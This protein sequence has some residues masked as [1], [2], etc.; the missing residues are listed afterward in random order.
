MTSS[1]HHKDGQ[2]DSIFANLI[3]SEWGYG[4]MFFLAPSNRVMCLLEGDGIAD[5]SIIGSWSTSGVAK[6]K[7]DSVTGVEVTAQTGADPLWACIQVHDSTG[8]NMLVGC[9]KISTRVLGVGHSKG[10][11]NKSLW[12]KDQGPEHS[13]IGCSGGGHANSHVLNFPHTS[14]CGRGHDVNT[15][16]C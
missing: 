2:L 10:L 9:I 5:Y 13:T 14:N 11:W 4:V 1:G 15:G 16:C 7:D 8:H 3:Y 6:K 12:N